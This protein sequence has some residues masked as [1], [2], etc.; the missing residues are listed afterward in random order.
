MEKVIKVKIKLTEEEIKN[1]NKTWSFFYH[2]ADMISD[3]E[4]IKLVNLS[5]DVTKK[6]SKFFN[7]YVEEEEE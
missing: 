4:D 3:E 1:L 2:L 6:I 5:C 7:E